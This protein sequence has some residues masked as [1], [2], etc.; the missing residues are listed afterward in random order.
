MGLKVLGRG[1]GPVVLTDQPW[2]LV[3]GQRA[4]SQ[5]SLVGGEGT[6][7]QLQK[8]GHKRPPAVPLE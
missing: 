7:T 5:A 8:L 1:P 4:G 3:P 6:C 2:D